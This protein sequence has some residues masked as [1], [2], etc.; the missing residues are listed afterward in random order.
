MIKTTIT[1]AYE[2]YHTSRTSRQ[3]FTLKESDGSG[4]N[5]RNPDIVFTSEGGSTDNESTDNTE[6]V[7]KKQN[8]KSKQKKKKPFTREQILDTRNKFVK[9]GL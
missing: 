4:E 5:I 1:F 2:Q 7:I 9:M 8:S 3:D 6:Q